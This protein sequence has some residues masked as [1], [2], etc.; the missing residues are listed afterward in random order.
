[1]NLGTIAYFT[2]FYFIKVLFLAIILY[3]LKTFTN[4]GH[5]L[6][7][8][9]K[10]KLF[11][12][13]ILMILL[14]GYLDFVISFYMYID[15]DP[16]YVSLSSE[17]DELSEF[18]KY[19][20]MILIF[21]VAPVSIIFVISHD[22]KELKSQVFQR[23]YG[24]IYKEFRHH[25]KLQIGFYL[26]FVL[27]RFLF[28]SIMFNMR[29]RSY[30]QIIAMNYLN[31]FMLIYHGNTRPFLSSFRSWVEI[32]N[33]IFIT[34]DTFHFM[35]FTDITEDVDIQF[36]V[37]WSLVVLIVAHIAFN[38]AIILHSKFNDLKLLVI[39]YR[40]RLQSWLGKKNKKGP[41]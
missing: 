24:T 32:T 3:P 39:K 13:E 9:L 5:Y 8:K 17:R 12:G 28:I 21:V 14:E 35:L 37:G 40:R 10:Q 33:E 2:G 16:F 38:M 30:F 41:E 23:D 11:F 34:I 27:R 29:D 15:Y 20:I 31:L 25:S 6:F 22:T 36:T 1:M 4:H 7:R 19:T 18:A 26:V